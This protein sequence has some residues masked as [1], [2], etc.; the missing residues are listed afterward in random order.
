MFGI[1][2]FQR[3]EGSEAQAVLDRQRQR[4]ASL[5]NSL[6][7]RYPL[8]CPLSL[9]FLG[10]LLIVLGLVLAIPARFKVALILI[11][12]PFL[13]FGSLLVLLELVGKVR[14]R[15]D[16]TSTS[17]PDPELLILESFCDGRVVHYKESKAEM[18]QLLARQLGFS[19]EEARERVNRLKGMG[20]IT[21]LSGGQW[22][23]N[24]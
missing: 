6:L 20:R 11:G 5:L 14:E 18:A 2:F 15:L 24:R 21:Y 19:L 1:S 12:G 23:L 13:V 16:R 4:E 10:V 7:E 9:L 8:G 22:V 17:P 3:Y